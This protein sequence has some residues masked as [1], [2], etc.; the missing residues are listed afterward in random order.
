MLPNDVMHWHTAYVWW[1]RGRCIA[2]Y[3]YTHT[4]IQSY[5]GTVNLLYV[6]LVFRASSG[7]PYIILVL[8]PCTICIIMHI[9]VKFQQAY[10]YMYRVLWQDNIHQLGVKV[11]HNFKWGDTV[12]FNHNSTNEHDSAFSMCAQ[13]EGKG[14]SLFEASFYLNKYWT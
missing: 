8:I 7:S 12:Y 13:G 14:W 3:T 4:Y 6:S 10:I 9:F 1:T 5:I 2:T 11:C